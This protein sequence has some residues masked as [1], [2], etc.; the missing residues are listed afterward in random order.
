MALK[1]EYVAVDSL[2]P[3]INNPRK[4]DRAVDIVAGSIAEFGFRNPILVDKAGV[5]IAGHT[6]LLAARKVGLKT[7][8][9]IRVEDLTPAQVK[10]YRIADNKTAEF[11]GWDLGM[12]KGEFQELQDSN[13]DLELTA[14]S[15]GEIEGV[16]E[17]PKALDIDG[18]AIADT[19][20]GDTKKQ[21][22]FCPKCG[23]E[24]EVRQ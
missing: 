22:C 21:T 5:I 9:V 16:M 19:N 3:Y 18:D 7:V 6:R 13:F 15:L 20:D 1:I 8:P 24:F 12:L 14:F 2:V 11:S 10:A 17:G 23:F 4:N